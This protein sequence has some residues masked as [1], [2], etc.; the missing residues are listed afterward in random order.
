MN[1]HLSTGIVV[2]DMF[3]A[4]IT[5]IA[6]SDA[7]AAGANLEVFATLVFGL[8]AGLCIGALIAANFAMLELEEKH[9]EVAHRQVDAHAH[10]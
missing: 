2:G 7:I 3:A 4:P 6:A 1:R 5:W 10:G 9:H 8:A